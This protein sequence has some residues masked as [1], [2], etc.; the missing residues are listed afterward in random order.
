[1]DKLEEHADW[2]EQDPDDAEG[3]IFRPRVK[4]KKAQVL[5]GLIEA[6]ALGLDWEPQSGITAPQACNATV[7]K[8]AN[9]A[10]VRWKQK[11]LEIEKQQQLA[12]FEAFVKGE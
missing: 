4:M 2:L 10:V 3:V 6:C 11:E 1:M 9:A 8:M 12:A 7:V 5:G